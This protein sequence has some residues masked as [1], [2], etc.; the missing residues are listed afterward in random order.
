VTALS[1]DCGVPI[2]SPIQRDRYDACDSPR[3]VGH[4]KFHTLSIATWIATPFTPRWKNVG[5]RRPCST[6]N[7]TGLGKSNMQ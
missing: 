1:R 3:Q 4:A 2:P 7:S 5:V 6:E